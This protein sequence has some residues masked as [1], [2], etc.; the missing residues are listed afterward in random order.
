MVSG[1]F[2]KYNQAVL[3]SEQREQ[4]AEAETSLSKQKQILSEEETKFKK[5]LR[6]ASLSGKYS[7]E[8]VLAAKKQIR[9]QQSQLSQSE[10]Q[11]KAAETQINAPLSQVKTPDQLE[12]QG[13]QKRVSGSTTTYYKEDSYKDRGKKKTFVEEEYTFVNGKPQKIIKRDDYRDGDR[14]RVDEEQI[15]EF[16]SSGTVKSFREYRDGER[17]EVETYDD[18]GRLTSETKYNREGKKEE[19]Q[20][21]TYKEDGSISVKTR[22]YAAERKAQEKAQAKQEAQ[23]A[24][25]RKYKQMTASVDWSGN[26][27]Y[28]ETA[29]NPDSGQ[30][31]KT[32]TTYT[33]QQQ[34]PTKKISSTK[35]LQATKTPIVSEQLKVKDI[36][37]LGL[38]TG[39]NQGTSTQN[40]PSINIKSPE[41]IQLEKQITQGVQSMDFST[42]ESV[43]SVQTQTS[44]PQQ[45]DA[46]TNV[47]ATAITGREVVFNFDSPKENQVNLNPTRILIAPYQVG[48]KIGNY[49]A[50][51]VK[52]EAS[53]VQDT[54]KVFKTV[55]SDPVG[56]GKNIVVGTV[57]KVA[58]DPFGFVGET[59]AL[60]G[61][62]RVGGG[63]V[64]AVKE[65]KVKVEPIGFETR[66]V[67]VESAASRQGVGIEQIETI[68]QV[69][70]ETGVF[71]K[72]SE[73]VDVKASGIINKETRALGVKD[74]EVG[75]FKENAVSTEFSPARVLEGD[76]QVAAK[77]KTTTVK[78]E[79]LQQEAKQIINVGDETFLSETVK[80]GKLNDETLFKTTTQNIKTGDLSIG[81]SKQAKSKGTD[82]PTQEAFATG[83]VSQTDVFLK[84]KDLEITPEKIIDVEATSFKVVDVPQPKSTP[85]IQGEFYNSMIDDSGKIKVEK[86]K[87][88]SEPIQRDFTQSGQTQVF[89]E[90]S[91]Q[92]QTTTD[93][94]KTEKSSLVDVEQSFKT[95]ETTPTQFTIPES[96]IKSLVV[97]TP[98]FELKPFVAV[99]N[100]AAQGNVPQ[101]KFDQKIGTTEERTQEPTTDTFFDQVIKQDVTPI[102]EVAPAFS[103][104][105]DTTTGQKQK[106]DQVF[107]E[108]T[109]TPT[110]TPI[111]KPEIPVEPPKLKFGFAWEG[112]GK[113]QKTQ[114]FSFKD[115][116]QYIAS[117]GGALTGLSSKNPTKDITGLKFRAILIPKGRKTL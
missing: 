28:T 99:Q 49:L 43:R 112:K 73:V 56:T 102:Q 85:M 98:K 59:L 27:E 97:E 82:L 26:S 5:G 7:P 81:L 55:V 104:K 108:I 4:I 75:I 30:W 37:Q 60:E 31:E 89:E 77:G 69:R 21:F 71:K 107:D 15:I 9:Q 41:Q 17:R 19:R 100:I 45:I 44:T 54:K 110:P 50:E 105:S 109:P 72:K 10:A 64:K 91:P 66:A 86:V 35:T 111:P 80:V 103:F 51:N 78:V 96:T 58:T 52:G 94:M 12:A 83:T 2:S 113:K 92:K 38:S 16:S 106:Q 62:A 39:V 24:E 11:I 114:E 22:D 61:A 29:F 70:V 57:E 23:L 46:L 25:S 87:P 88:K 68:G 33:K 32:T 63:A 3:A 40:I 74:P 8:A 36:Q 101:F 18:L 6:A 20:R 14:R 93:L 116:G 65:S 90:I 76:I 53:I 115:E 34:V 13:Y 48:S 95:R 84:Q 47:K 1:D 42:P 79:G 67:Q 117:L